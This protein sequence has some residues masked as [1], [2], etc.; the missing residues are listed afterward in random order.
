VRIV[1]EDGELIVVEK[2]A[3][4]L[5][6][7]T[8]KEKHRTLYARLREHVRRTGGGR[9]FIVHRLDRE[10]SGLLVFAKTA[11]AKY[12]LQEQFR[13]REAGRIYL[14]VVEG[15]FEPDTRTL[16]SR[17]AENKAFKVYAT[18][19]EGAGRPAVTHVR[20]LRRGGGRSLLEVT[21]ETGRK[22]QIRVQ[23]A[24]IGH[25]ILGDE[26][27]GSGKSASRHLALHAATLRFR[28]PHTGQTLE[29]RSRPS[30]AADPIWRVALGSGTPGGTPDRPRREAEGRTKP[31]PARGVTPPRGPRRAR[32]P[33]RKPPRRRAD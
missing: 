1:H 22:H 7:A 3:G 15:V 2:P 31:E 12:D 13:R 23:L 29:F 4:L 20:V 8:E 28:H 17:L 25:P 27:Y 24:D 19:K 21:L 32:F 16:H 10:A 30:P 33:R 6:I 26:R 14:A 18:R 9:V 11:E 5:T